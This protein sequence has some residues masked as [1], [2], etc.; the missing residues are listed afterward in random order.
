MLK[1][2]IEKMAT[3]Q[4]FECYENFLIKVSYNR[5]IFNISIDIIVNELNYFCL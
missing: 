4:K 2:Y 3:K 1:A 5:R